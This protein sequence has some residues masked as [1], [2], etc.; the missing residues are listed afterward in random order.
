[1]RRE[2]FNF[3]VF[4]VFI[5]LG[6]NVNPTYASNV[7]FEEINNQITLFKNDQQQGLIISGEKGSVVID[8]LNQVTAQEIKSYLQSNNKSEIT[9]IVYS[10]SHWDRIKG[11]KTFSDSKPNIIAQKSCGLYFSGNKNKQV[12][13][14]TVYFDQAYTINIGEEVIDL[15]YFGPSHGECMLVAELKNS[16]LLFIPDLVSTQGPGFPKDPTLPF[17]R[18]AT[19]NVFFDSVQNLIDSKKI[20]YFISGHANDLALGSI[21]IV[22][23]QKF[24][25]ELIQAMTIIAEEEGLVDLNNFIAVE[26]MNLE[27]IKQ[28]ENFNEKDLVN[29]LRRYTSFLNMGR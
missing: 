3:I 17:L 9:D 1:M 12:V 29:I 8:P 25:W 23:Q 13:E 16:K 22:G 11:A 4:G 18:P 2:L 24:F 21:A 19:L 10:H 26:K 20:D 15:H 28:Y 27:E 7:S 14:P 5:A 6:F